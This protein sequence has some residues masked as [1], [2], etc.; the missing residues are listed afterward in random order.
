[1]DAAKDVKEGKYLKTGEKMYLD[2]ALN[3]I[4]YT[5]NY[6]YGFHTSP[7]R[8]IKFDTVLVT[9]PILANEN[10]TLIVDA[11]SGYDEAETNS[12][13]IYSQLSDSRKKVIGFVV[14]NAGIT[15]NGQAITAR[16]IMEIG[17]GTPIIVNSFG[18]N[19]QYWWTREGGNCSDPNNIVPGLGAPV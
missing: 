5:L 7:Y 12:R 6:K 4:S 19:D 18:P 2:T 3:Y 17:Y 13:L 14:Q 11:L 1:M 8:S 15:T 10:K 16:I 9:I